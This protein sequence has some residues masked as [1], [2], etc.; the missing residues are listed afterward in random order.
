MAALELATFG[1]TVNCVSP[2]SAVQYGHAP[3]QNQ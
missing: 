1:V 2:G 3:I